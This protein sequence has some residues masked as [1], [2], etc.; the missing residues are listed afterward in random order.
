LVADLLRVGFHLLLY[1]P[2]NIVVAAFY[3]G[4]NGIL[5]PIAWTIDLADD[6]NR[7][8]V[9]TMHFPHSNQVG[10]GTVLNRSVLR[11]RR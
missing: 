4:R 6:N 9:A 7:G 8:A 3:T 11:K 5:S 10:L 2:S 1:K